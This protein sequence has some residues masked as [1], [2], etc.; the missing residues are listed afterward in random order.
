MGPAEA[1]DDVAV[2]GL[3][4][5]GLL[6]QPHALFHVAAL[7][8]P[9]IAE[10]IENQRLIGGERQRALQVGLGGRPVLHALIGRAAR[11]VVGPVP[12]VRLADEIDG[13][14]EIVDRVGVALARRA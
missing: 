4:L 6:D 13:L 9:G 2:V 10:V 5:H 12:V 3:H 11:V 8:D 7:V 1:I 14:R